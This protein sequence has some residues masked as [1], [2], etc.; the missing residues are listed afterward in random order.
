VIVVSLKYV[1]FVMRASNHGEGGI[2]ALM[3]LAL[4]TAK[5]GS[6]QAM[7]IMVMGVLGACLFYGD[8]VITPAISVL[9]AIEGLTVVSEDFAHV[10][11]P[12]TLVILIMLFLFEKKALKLLVSFLGPS[13]WSGLSSLAPWGLTKLPK[14]LRS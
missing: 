1:A 7:A 12:I 11:L 10:V 5:Q 8:A 14:G 2:L 3:A 6:T 4:R 9:S 13:W